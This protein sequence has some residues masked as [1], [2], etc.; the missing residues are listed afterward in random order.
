VSVSTP[1]LEAPL[2]GPVFLRS[3]SHNLPDV[4]LALKGPPD[5]PIDFEVPTRIDS[6][7]GGL[8]AIA[9]DTPDVPVS[10]VDLRMQ[11]GQKGLFVN[12]TDICARTHRADLRLVAHN[13]RRLHLRPV[14]KATG[15]GGG[16]GARRGR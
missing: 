4:V 15:C 3:S 9:S 7:K 16:R 2:T 10:E 13:N 1:I 5:F 6:I 8:R 12:S 14:L 11:G